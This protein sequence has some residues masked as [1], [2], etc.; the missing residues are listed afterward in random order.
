MNIAAPPKDGEANEE[1]VDF[2]SN[3]LDIKKNSISLQKG[4]KC[5]NKLL[6][7]DDAS[8]SN[9]EEIYNILKD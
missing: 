3:V 4:G 6:E 7:I 2:F 5:R 9:V 1:L 8:C